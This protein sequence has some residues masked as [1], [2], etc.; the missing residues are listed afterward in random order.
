MCGHIVIRVHFL[1]NSDPPQL[2]I[3]T[4]EAGSSSKLT[5]DSW[6]SLVEELI[7]SISHGG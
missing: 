4:D 3:T 7:A 5:S 6:I 1:L 2:S